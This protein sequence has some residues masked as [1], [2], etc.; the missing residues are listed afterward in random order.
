MTVRNLN[1]MFRPASVAL[2][3]ASA[4]D[5]S[6]GKAIARNLLDGGFSGDIWL[7]NRRHSEVLGQR[8]YRSVEA[9]PAAPDLAVVATPP[10]AVQEVIGELAAK[11]CCAAIVI[12]AGFGEGD[13]ADGRRRAQAI[14][15]IAKPHLMRILGPNCVGLILPPLGL[16]ASFAPGQVLPGRL[17]FV[18]Q[19][20]AVITAVA[21]W[22]T[23]RGIGFSHM[24]SMGG[25]LDVDLGDVLDYLAQD[26]ETSAV[27]L[28][29][30]AVTTARK[31]MSAARALAR[32]K[33]VIVMKSGRHP[34][35]AM[36]AASHTGA[37]AGSDQVYDA[38]FRRAG[39]VRVRAM[40]EMFAAVETL[41]MARRPRTNRLCIVSNGGGAGVLATDS[42]IDYG[43]R[44]SSL[45]PE[46]VTRLDALLP[47]T[48]SRANPVD[49]IGDAG[50]ERYTAALDALAEDPDMGAILALNAPTALASSSAAAQAVADWATAH[51]EMPLLTSWL[52]GDK[53]RRAREIFTTAKVPTYDTPND[54]VRAFTHLVEY[55]RRREALMETPPATANGPPPDRDTVSGIIASVRADGRTMLTEPE[56]KAVLAAYHIPVAR[57]ETADDA[58]SAAETAAGFAGPY[59][60]KVL[61]RDI[62]HK[63]DVGGVALNLPDAAAVGEAANAMASRLRQAAPDARLDG[64]T[65]QEM[66]ARPGAHELIVGLARHAPFG[67]VVLVGQGG[68]AAEAVAD[69]AMALPPLN[70][71]LAEEALR[72]IRLWRLLRGYRDRPAA[73]IAAIGQTMIRIGELAADVADIAELDINPLLADEA[74]VIALDA[75]VLLTA[76]PEEEGERAARFAIRPYPAE[77]PKALDIGGDRYFLRPVRPEDEAALVSAFKELSPDEVRLR[78]FSVIKS[79]RHEM[80]ARLTQIDYDR[81]M[82]F[83]L[84]EGPDDSGA[85]LGIARFSADPDFDTAE[86]AITVRSRAQ[87]KGYGRALMQELIAYAGSR[88]IGELFGVVL[89]DNRP[90]LALAKSLG[91][92]QGHDPSEPGVVRVSLRLDDRGP[93]TGYDAAMSR[94]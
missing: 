54:A 48:W 85:A 33:P 12:T 2:I 19:S 3:G 58:A 1:L 93:G 28:Y 25:M 40:D 10:G 22:A 50:P 87:G 91:F 21:D 61:S 8:S 55:Y 76:T 66:I 46:T 72:R 70:P 4:R 34:E 64:F 13:D 14:L 78:F 29:A 74:G 24:I 27:L 56:A 69:T 63:T 80:A 83:V 75:R 68:T 45:A 86:F 36:A 47:P 5:G 41:A 31:F 90:M 49:I 71:L 35:G 92:R 53:A 20:G 23:D 62:S 18:S 30:E 15:D 65:V 6:V 16:N 60:L 89:A 39:F 88:G 17:A 94:A 79:M 73:D 42:L 38:A 82:A 52:G 37:L 84:F 59:A 43:G 32:A 7:V 26:R 9:L 11:G 44:L 67:P 81:E 51:P 77:L 57:T